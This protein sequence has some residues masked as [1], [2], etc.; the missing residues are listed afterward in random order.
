MQ[1]AKD[2]ANGIQQRCMAAVKKSPRTFSQ[3]CYQ[4]RTL[5]VVEHDTYVLCNTILMYYVNTTSK[6]TFVLISRPVYRWV[7]SISAN[8][9]LDIVQSPKGYIS[10]FLNFAFGVVCDMQDL[11]SLIPCQNSIM[12]SSTLCFLF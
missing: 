7:V 3:W 2:Y 4:L 12:F 11:Y 6:I 5:K 10:C 8:I 9:D 1:S